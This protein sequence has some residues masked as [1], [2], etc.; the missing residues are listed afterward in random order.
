MTRRQPRFSCTCI[1]CGSDFVG[2]TP[3]A[4][5]CGPSCRKERAR[6]RAREAARAK[7]VPPKPRDCVQCGATYTSARQDVVTC[8]KECRRKHSR[9]LAQANSRKCDRPDCDNPH[10]AKGL[11]RSH[12]YKAYPSEKRYET[13]QCAVCQTTSTRRYDGPKRAA[14]Y[15]PTCSSRCRDI[16]HN[17]WRTELPADHAAR[18]YGQRMAVAYANCGFCGNLFAHDARRANKAYCSQH[19]HDSRP[20]FVSASCND[21]GKPVMLDRQAFQS[22]AGYGHAYCGTA[23]NRRASKRRRRAREYNAP[24]EFRW[25]D[26]I[27]LWLALGKCCAY[28]GVQS[29]K[30]PDP[31]HVIPLSRGGDNTIDNILPA[32]RACNSQKRTLTI[33]EWTVDRQERRKPPLPHPWRAMGWRRLEHLP[34]GMHR[35]VA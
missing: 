28:C 8:S 33:A 31:D 11:C 3:W 15:L 6:L 16:I 9:Q 2:V 29:D 17:G 4:T 25:V 27:G 20:R 21:C 22:T 13:V 30:Q 24:G 35:D 19:S 14:K 7:R 32:C 23:C 1:I 18:W 10:I 26:M 12:Y 5:A 34:G